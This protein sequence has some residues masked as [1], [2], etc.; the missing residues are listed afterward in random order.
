MESILPQSR[1]EEL[2][3]RT[4]SLEDLLA[5]LLAVATIALFIANGWFDHL[6]M[7]LQRGE[8]YELD[9]FVGAGSILLLTALIMLARREWQLRHR[10][11]SSAAREH[12]AN[13][14]A[15]HDFLTG[16]AN[17]LALLERVE[18][19]RSRDVTFL[20]I[21]LDG[22]KRI[23]D[24]F[25]HDA[26][27]IV[28]KEVSRRLSTLTEA[29]QGAM[30]ARLGGDEFGCLLPSLPGDNSDT[31]IRDLIQSLEAPI[32]VRDQDVRVGASVGAYH[33]HGGVLEADQMLKI[34]DMAMYRSKE[35]AHLRAERRSGISQAAVEMVRNR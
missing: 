24:H 15:R 34:A 29:R 16:I 2:R 32:A 8:Q 20:L 21:D 11:Q 19:L 4:L 31:M 9:E 14:A 18:E 25:G 3:P 28:L 33:S 1:V 17:R 10:L 13:E 23:N 6:C 12:Q 22:F 26:G 27:D 7:T 35:G 5:A 30:A